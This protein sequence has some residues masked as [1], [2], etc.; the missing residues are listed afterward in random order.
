MLDP[1]DR[2]VRFTHPSV[3][4]FLLDEDNPA[5]LVK[6]AYRTGYDTVIE[7]SQS[8]A[9]VLKSGR[10]ECAEF[11]INYLSFSD[12]GSQVEKTESISAA[13][14]TSIAA[15]VLQNLPQSL[16]I[17]LGLA[18]RAFGLKT[19]RSQDLRSV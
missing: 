9:I 19:K 3:R 15:P 14:P 6:E 18:A 5:L 11:S 12:F 10:L 4:E 16:A 13:L 8:F 1:F 7:Q 2:H 17:P